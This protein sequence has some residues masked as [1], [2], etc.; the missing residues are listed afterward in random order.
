MASY[1][2]SLQSVSD[3]Y[4]REVLVQA[5]EPPHLLPQSSHPISVYAPCAK[6]TPRR[7]HYDSAIVVVQFIF[8]LL[9]IVFFLGGCILIFQNMNKI[10]AITTNADQTMANVNSKQ[11]PVLDTMEKMV[12]KMGDI[13]DKL[14]PI[15]DVVSHLDSVLGEIDSHKDSIAALGSSMVNFASSMDNVSHDMTTTAKKVTDNIA[16]NGIKVQIAPG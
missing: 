1:E 14:D 2:V 10:N 12:N 7:G 11:S 8:Y 9:G 15:N 16:I 13:T 4:G 3:E 5:E 6:Q